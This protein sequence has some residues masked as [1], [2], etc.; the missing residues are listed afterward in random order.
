MPGFLKWLLESSCLCSKHFINW[1]ISPVLSTCFTLK[2]V[3][4]ERVLRIIANNYILLNLPNNFIDWD[5]SIHQAGITKGRKTKQMSWGRSRS[6]SRSS[7]NSRADLATEVLENPHGLWLGG[8]WRN[9]L[10]MNPASGWLE[11]ADLA[12]RIATSWADYIEKG[13]RD[14]TGNV[15]SPSASWTWAQIPSIYIKAKCV[16]VHCNPSTTGCRQVDPRRLL[17]S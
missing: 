11:P 2:T 4:F 7:K 12:K 1:T 16:S 8:A 3:K 10:L 15:P 9:E 5:I 6:H 14:G 13:W 17:A